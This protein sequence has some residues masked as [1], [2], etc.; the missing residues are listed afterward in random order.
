MPTR[1]K[2]VPVKK[3]PTEA[4]VLKQASAV[5]G[6]SD[7]KRLKL[8]MLMAAS[9]AASESASFAGRVRDAYGALPVEQTR[10]NGKQTAPT[11][12]TLDVRPVKE[13]RGFTLNL[14]EPVNPYLVYEAYGE[15]QMRQILD[16]FSSAALKESARI[17]EERNPGTKLRGRPTKPEL[18]D[19]IMTFVS[20]SA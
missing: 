2:S 4:S 1:T 8:A 10:A 9:D 7:T 6:L 18:I 17:V 12:L 3:A 13:V 11:L 14:G 16:V 15:R 20:R 19:Y 5:L